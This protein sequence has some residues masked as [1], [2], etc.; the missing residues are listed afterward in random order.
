MRRSTI[1]R[2]RARTTEPSSSRPAT[3]NAQPAVNVAA[4]RIVSRD[5]ISPP[6]RVLAFGLAAAALGLFLFIVVRQIAEAG[7]YS[8]DWAIQN[9]W[10]TYGFS[11]AVS[12]Q[13]DIL[14]AKPLLGILLIG[15]YEV[16]GTN[17]AWH[18][19]LLA[20]L[21]IGCTVGF[22]FVLRGLRLPP[23]DAIPIALLA[24]LFPWASSVRLW[25][26]GGLNNFAVLLLFGGF[27]IALR[28]LRVDGWRGILIHLAAT[29]CYVASILVYEVTTGLALFAWIAYVWLGGRRR[30]L[31]RMALDVPA[32]AATAIYTGENTNKH[33]ETI[34]AQLDHVPDVA[35][36]GAKLIADTFLPV[37]IPAEI[38]VGLT[39]I[40]IA[41]AA[42]VLVVA[43][44]RPSPG[45]GAIRWPAVA[46][47]ALGALALCWAIYV[48]QA[49]YT[50]TFRGVEDRVNILALYPASVLVWAVLQAA[51]SLVPRNG[52]VLAVAGA[53]AVAVGFGIQDIRQQDQWLRSTELQ[54]GVLSAVE[55][56][57][58]PE[59]SVVLVFGFPAET[60]RGVPVFDTN[61]DLKP[62][63]Q[64]RLSST[65]IATYPVFAGSTI[66]C[67]PKGI[68]LDYLATPLYQ[69]ISPLEEG[70]AR[71]QPYGNVVFAEA[72]RHEL[73][74]S[75]GQCTR[76]LDEYT[77]G[78]WLG[79]SGA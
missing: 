25:P 18:H 23:R 50:P 29:A 66:R 59:G 47:A 42:G 20:L 6:V 7:F 5:A 43:A 2:W 34:T 69:R 38:S 27:L 10:H 19:L 64:L 60:A 55:R 71:L 16:L 35:G 26:T 41:A 14:G 40:V 22:Y 37:S 75:R 9:E 3:V 78:P 11:E 62:A 8:D 4:L 30:A 72:R 46:L 44:V 67:S 74:R 79:R 36:Q 52:Y 17:P 45:A 24:L 58:P 54:P 32:V 49:F 13:F 31:P 70:T 56:A 61:Y 73:I 68:A 21:S 15:S 28:A 51:G 33:V 63:A 65:T 48:P 53:V 57:H 1:A 39:V 12:R 77:P 76:A